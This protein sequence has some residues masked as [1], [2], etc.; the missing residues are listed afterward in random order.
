MDTVTT[1]PKEADTKAQKYILVAED[2]NY[3]AN[4]FKTKLTKEGFEVGIVGNGD[5]LLKS[6]SQRRPDLIIL[7]LIMPVKDGF[8]ALK[9][10]RADDKLKDIKVMVI[11]NLGQDD[12]MEKTRTLG[13]VDY[14]IKTNTSVAEMVDRVQRALE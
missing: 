2:D 1:Q 6:A 9:E 4:V 7:D 13:V 10:L 3:Y 14:L 12:D 5:A 8:E 11:S